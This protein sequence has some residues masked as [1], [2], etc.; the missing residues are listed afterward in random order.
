MKRSFVIVLCLAMIICLWQSLASAGGPPP[1]T[2]SCGNGDGSANNPIKICTQ[3][4]FT[5][6]RTWPA[7]HFVLGNSI[8]LTP[9]WTPILSFEGTFDAKYHWIVGLPAPFIQDNYGTVKNL[10]AKKANVVGNGTIANVNLGRL[11]SVYAEGNVQGGVKNGGLVGVNKGVI[12]WS[13]FTGEIQGTAISGGIAGYNE[14]TG[15]IKQSNA[16]GTSGAFSTAGGLVGTNAG[17][18]KDSYAW[19]I[20]SSSSGT[21]GGLVGRNHATGVIANSVATGDV[22]TM[23]TAIEIGKLVGLNSGKIIRSYGTG[24]IVLYNG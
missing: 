2:T 20:A 8:D 17:S 19:G 6:M 10:V 9:D 4:D 11:T 18:I 14:A 22:H 7:S 15:S 21:V 12:E 16:G 5:A 13:Q 1:K 23:D 3:A 24:Q